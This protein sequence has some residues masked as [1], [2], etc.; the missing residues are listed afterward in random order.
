MNYLWIA[1]L[2]ASL[3]AQ[4][5]DIRNGDESTPLAGVW[6]Q[7]TGDDLRWAD[8]ALDDS[9]WTSITMPR[10]AAAGALGYT[11]HRIHVSVPVDRNLQ[12]LIGP[13]FPAYEIFANGAK[14][15]S[16][17]GEVGTAARQHYATPASFALPQG[18]AKVVLAIRSYDVK[19]WMGA[20]SGSADSSRSWIGSREEMAGKIAAWNYDAIRASGYSRV[21]IADLDF[22]GRNRDQPANSVVALAGFANTVHRRNSDAVPAALDGLS[23]L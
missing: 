3:A 2:A 23:L 22:P 5:I 20:Q 15:G 21:L 17:G 10:P 18:P 7:K 11:W 1:V 4:T 19:L 13:L 9:S 6:K 8:P 14:I 16:F 12:V